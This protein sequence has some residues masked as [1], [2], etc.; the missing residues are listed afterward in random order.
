M[1]RSLTAGIDPSALDAMVE[2]LITMK[3]T[4]AHEPRVTPVSPTLASPTSVETPALVAV[5]EVA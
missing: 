4:L 3:T 5:R 1:A 2:V